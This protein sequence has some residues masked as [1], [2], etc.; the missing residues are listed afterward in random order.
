MRQLLVLI[1]FFGF[2]L[3]VLAQPYR[4]V[5]DLYKRKKY[6]KA[7]ELGKEYLQK[8]TA[9]GLLNM[10]VGSSYY[11]KE[12]YREAISYLKK[13]ATCTNCDSWVKAW[14]M[15]DLGSSYFMVDD[16]NMAKTTLRACLKPNA[17]PLEIPRE[18][19]NASQLL[20]TYA[21]TENYD[22]W[23]IVETEHF[24]FH[25]QDTSLL[26]N[27]KTYT[28]AREESYMRINEYFNV[29]PSKRIDFYLWNSPDSLK[30]EIGYSYGRTLPKSCMVHSL[31]NQTHGSEIAL[32]LYE[33]SVVPS[34]TSRFI[35]EGVTTYFDQSSNSKMSVAKKNIGARVSV[36]DLW[37]KPEK[38]PKTYVY[39]IGAAFV[40]FL[41]KN[42]TTDQLKQLLN[43]QTIKNAKKV[44]PNFDE[45]V[46]KFEKELYNWKV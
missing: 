38:F 44:Y 12:C 40:E 17:T 10:F 24:R 1:F 13:S 39:Q 30:A 36:I 42:G 11:N 14:S 35:G 21:L 25:I 31:Y 34:E 32:I 2:S 8:D 33:H 46:F 6:D 41:V 19:K 5:Y 7:I 29:K 9:S 43:D 27:L 22:S 3:S 4:D 28:E 45:L 16:Y 15:V 23:T 18:K 37:K 26:G 20:K